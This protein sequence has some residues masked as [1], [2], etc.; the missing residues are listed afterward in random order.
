VATSPE[1]SVSQRKV[2]MDGISSITISGT[3]EES[4]LMKFE[5]KCNKGR[6]TTKNN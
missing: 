6:R 2:F 5:L 1:I 3:T 4:E